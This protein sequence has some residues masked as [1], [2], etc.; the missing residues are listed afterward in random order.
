[1]QFLIS[2][3]AE[4]LTQ[5]P[6]VLRALLGVKSEAWLAARK[7]PDSFTPIDVLGHLVHCERTDWIPRVRLMLEHGDTKPFEPIDRFGHRSWM[8][9]MS[10]AR[11]LDEFAG[12]RQRNVEELLGLKLTEEQLNLPGLHPE[13]GKVALKNHLASWVVHDLGHIDQIVKSM[14]NEYR[15]EVGPWRSFLAILN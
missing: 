1:M 11:L 15:A 10:V 5:T 7:T 14:A 3:A 13:L 2:Q 8:A 6:G 4:V 9:G 12:L